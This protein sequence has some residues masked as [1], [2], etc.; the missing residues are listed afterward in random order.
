MA[1]TKSPTVKTGGSEKRSKRGRPSGANLKKRSNQRAMLKYGRMVSG[2][3]SVGQ[4]TDSETD[5]LPPESLISHHRLPVSQSDPIAF[6]YR[7]VEPRGSART[8]DTAT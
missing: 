7:M 5:L 3:T 8:T 4:E 6:A 2:N 1:C